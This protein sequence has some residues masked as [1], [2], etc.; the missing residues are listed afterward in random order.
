M[1]TCTLTFSQL[2]EDNFQPRK[3]MK[4]S[5]KEVTRVGGMDEV[6]PLGQRRKCVVSSV[7]SMKGYSRN[8]LNRHFSREYDVSDQ[9]TI[10][11]ISTTRTSPSICPWVF[12]I[13]YLD[14]FF[15]FLGLYA[16]PQGNLIFQVD[17]RAFFVIFWSWKF[18][19]PKGVVRRRFCVRFNA[20]KNTE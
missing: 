8:F 5:K 2:D 19:I 14:L 15:V 1:N 6:K 12:E 13:P 9:I 7:L 16:F 10:F 11:F 20:W 17:P 18:S 3:A 4:R